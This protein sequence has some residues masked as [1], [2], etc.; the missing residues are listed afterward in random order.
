MGV[1]EGEVEEMGELFIFEKE[2]KVNIK[3]K[4]PL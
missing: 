4:S 2:R 3:I 1:R